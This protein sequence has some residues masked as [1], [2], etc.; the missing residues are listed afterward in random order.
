[1]RRADSAFRHREDRADRLQR[2]AQWL[3]FSCR[4]AESHSGEGG[5]RATL[6][7]QEV[8]HVREG[9]ALQQNIARRDGQR[10]VADGAENRRRASSHAS[11]P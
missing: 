8:A 9:Y 1:M 6:Y 3:T 2:G 5:E 7:V 10:G 4:G 11:S